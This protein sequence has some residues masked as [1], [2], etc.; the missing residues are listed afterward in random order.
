MYFETNFKFYNEWKFQHD[1]YTVDQL[2]R[3]KK[4]LYS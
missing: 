2:E 1:E 4:K 3:T